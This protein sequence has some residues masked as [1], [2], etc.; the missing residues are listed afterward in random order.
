MPLNSRV[1][2]ILTTGCRRKIDDWFLPDANGC[3]VP[4]RWPPALLWADRRY[5]IGAKAWAADAPSAGSGRQVCM[6]R[7]NRFVVSEDIQFDKAIAAFSK[8]TG[9]LTS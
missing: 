9:A 6:L 7:W 3:A 2:R 1:C 4:L 8:A 5:Q